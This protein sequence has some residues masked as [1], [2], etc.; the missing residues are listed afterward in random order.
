MKEKINLYK[1]K[2]TSYWR[3]RSNKQRG[4]I[5]GTAITVI[6]LAALGVYL[7]SRTKMVPL[8]SDLTLQEVGQVK[9][10]LDTRGVDYELQGGGQTIMVPESEAESLL[11]DLAA[12]G[13][14]DSGKIDYSFFSDNTS[15]GMT[16]KEFDVIK[17]DA[18]Q[19]ELANLIS[20]IAGIQDAEVMINAPEDEIFL[21]DAKQ[22]A[23]ASIVLKVEPGYQVESSK[24]E[25]LYNL[26]SKSVPN[27]PKD[28]IVIMDQNFNY[29]DINNPNSG[30]EGTYTYQQ[31]VKKDIERDIQ[32]RVQRMLAMMIGQQKV[33]ATVTADIDFTKENRVENIVEP[34]DPDS[35]DGLPVSVERIEETY[36]GDGASPGG[37][38]GEGEEDVSSYQGEDGSSGEYSMNK[39][40]INN[41]FN[42][43]KKNIEESP[44]KVR[45]LG[46][47]VAI[48]S[49]KGTDDQGDPLLLSQ[50]EQ[51]TVQDSVQSILNSM[52]TTSI[53]ED[54]GEVN[55]AD[56]VSI[57]FQEFNGEPQFTDEPQGIP[58]WMYVAGGVL[59][60]VIA[61]LIWM[62]A[63]RKNEV[64]EEE[65]KEIQQPIPVEVPD[66]EEKE[67]ESTARRKQLERMAKDKPEDFAKLLRT[68]IA[69]D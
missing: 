60:A 34:V 48:D 8:Y 52:I 58:L 6:L 57:V 49:K 21:T 17:V 64:E 47:Q 69:E 67:T 24:V 66:I 9:A 7:S 56:K 13:M 12:S 36:T 1:E 41:E 55:P 46:I 62:L 16:D 15:W 28:N 39:E 54:Y 27:L 44:Y 51:Q 50:Q 3:Q 10:E 65:F 40:T 31:K 4:M 30:E 25:A 19:S 32:Q 2:I 53:N 29:Y 20:G 38:P 45:D 43:I 42:R 63:R 23:S 26:A 5:V 14:P 68:W 22:E 37:V 18:M 11:V 33:I 35:M 61:V 59:L